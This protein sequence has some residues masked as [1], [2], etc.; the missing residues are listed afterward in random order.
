MQYQNSAFP[1]LVVIYLYSQLSV[2]SVLRKYKFK[3]YSPYLL[4]FVIYN[5]YIMIIFEYGYV[6]SYQVNQKKITTPGTRRHL[7]QLS[8]LRWQLFIFSFPIPHY[9]RFFP[10]LLTFVVVYFFPPLHASALS[11]FKASR[12]QRI[13][14]VLKNNF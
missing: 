7:T 3:G 4:Y 5:V 14:V 2:S 1:V 8:R 9:H 10:S 12:A 11:S 13:P 6:A